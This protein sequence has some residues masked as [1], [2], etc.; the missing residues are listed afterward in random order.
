[1]DVEERARQAFEDYLA[2]HRS[3]PEGKTVSERYEAIPIFIANAI[4]E[5]EREMQERCA[6][7]VETHAAARVEYSTAGVDVVR[8]DVSSA[9][10]DALAR[11]IR[12]IG[13][14]ERDEG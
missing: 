10:R 12:A 1:M 2:W 9:A 7:F 14:G 6:R 11:G 13:K 5:A 4:R 3:D 8:S